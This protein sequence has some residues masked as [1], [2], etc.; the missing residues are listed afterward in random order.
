MCAHCK[1]YDHR[2][3]F[4]LITIKIVILLDDVSTA[5][6]HSHSHRYCV[7]ISEFCHRN[8]SARCSLKISSSQHAL[9]YKKLYYIFFSRRVR[10]ERVSGE[11]PTEFSDILIIITIARDFRTIFAEF[12]RRERIKY[13]FIK[14]ISDT[15]VPK[16][17]W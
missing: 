3:N 16:L 7:I 1:I 2:I 5:L 11:F 13:L 4:S 14:K 6:E 10:T 9:T 17:R 12:H 15:C 8:T